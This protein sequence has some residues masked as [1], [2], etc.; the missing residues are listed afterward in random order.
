MDRRDFLRFFGA[1]AAV[2]PLVGGLPHSDA[3]G[4]LV[5]PANIIPFDP[6]VEVANQAQMEAMVK[7]GRMVCTIDITQHKPSPSHFR[8]TGGSFVIWGDNGTLEAT[9]M[10]SIDSFEPPGRWNTDFLPE[11][12]RPTDVEITIHARWRVMDVK[13]GVVDVTNHSSYFRTK[14]RAGF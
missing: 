13:P 7:G 14:K 10:Q 5:Q 12:Q 9:A 8:Y 1:G 3:A 11:L 4:T 2:V 6:K